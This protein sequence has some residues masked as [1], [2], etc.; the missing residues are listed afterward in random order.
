MTEEID[1]LAPPHYASKYMHWHFVKDVGMG[2]FDGCATKYVTRWRTKDGVEGLKKSLHFVN[3][4]IRDENHPMV[5]IPRTKSKPE[6]FACIERFSR[7]NDLHELEEQI[8]ARLALGPHPGW[9]TTSRDMILLLIDAAE[10]DKYPPYRSDSSKHA[11][12]GGE[13]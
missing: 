13:E 11:T 8:V 6:L 10:V 9:L 3:E 1:P 5:A 4:M 12:V 2:Y 7:I